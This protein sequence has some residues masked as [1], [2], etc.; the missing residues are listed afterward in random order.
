[1]PR[2]GRIFH[3]KRRD[4]ETAREIESYLE[5]EAERHAA[6][7]LS[8]EAARDAARRKLGN[9]TQIH[10]EIYRMNTLGFL[11]AFVKDVA[12]GW[13]VLLKA[14]G[15]TLIGVLSLALGIGA[16]TTMFSVVHAVLLRPLP[17]P[18]PEQVMRIERGSDQPAVTIPE[19]QF[20]KANAPVFASAAGYRG[21]SEMSLDAGNRQEPVTALT[22]TDDFFRTL[23]MPLALGREFTG[24]E[25]HPG[26]ARAM[27]LGNELWRRAFGAAPDAVGRVVMLDN[28]RYTVVGVAPRG[29][30]FPLAADAYVPVQIT[31]S[32][33]DR[34]M[35][36][37]MFARLKPGIG[38]SPPNAALSSALAATA[39]SFRESGLGP[40]DHP[41]MQAIPYQQSIVG[42][43]RL[44]LL[45]LFGVV[46]ALLLIAC[47]NLSGLLLARFAARQKEVAV[48]L[49]LGSGSARLVAQF[50]AENA[51][52]TAAGCGAG[53]LGAA[54]LL[55]GITA[56]VPFQL[57]AGGPIGVDT[58]TLVFALA[59]SLAT[60]LAFSFAP[61]VAARRMAVYDTLKSGG[62]STGGGTVRLGARSFL[63]VTEV[64]LS[65][66]LLVSAAL[67]IQSLYRM[68]HEPLGFSPQGVIA[69]TTPAE[70]YRNAE[71]QKAFER[72][73][74]D[75]LTN[76]PGVRAAGAASQL[77]L[78]GHSNLPTEP[79]GHPELNIGG[80][81]VRI[82]TPGYF[83]ALR[84]P[85]A[86]GRALAATDSATASPV[87]L[88]NETVARKWWAHE[89]PLGGQVIV[90]R[91]QGRD[92]MQDLEPARQVVG[93]VADTKTEFLTQPAYPTVY[94]AAAQAAR[95]EGGKSWVVRAGNTAGL[96]E[97]LR[98]TVAEIDPRQ[99]IR[100]MREMEDIVAANTTDS[101][102]DAWL[103]GVF[104]ALA[105]TLTAIGVYGLLAFSV[106]RRTNEFGI[107][108]ALGASR[109][110]VMRLVLRQGAALIT[111]GLVAGLAGSLALTKFLSSLLYSVKPRD[112]LS[113]AAVAVVL[114]LS[115]LAASTYRRYLPARYARRPAVGSDRWE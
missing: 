71:A 76:L 23:G 70:R 8:P 32:L 87:I 54:W 15:Y 52:L 10:E 92:F 93:I 34:G 64:A 44:K 75:R 6:R 62:R 12:Y 7:G 24:A 40:R 90:G 67:L 91:F 46:G 88:V 111:I 53:L 61:L 100:Q 65:V 57:P 41:G 17:Y 39:A 95:S 104:A 35:N 47:L 36:T 50:L 72:D 102:F 49:A 103:F 51:L 27:V 79:V 11:E 59:I 108:L 60:T 115:F 84:I 63:V 33:G 31:N 114:Q 21:T 13:R 42:D 78:T 66:T 109:P 112:P 77:P 16:N 83:A 99:R 94:I 105:L 1:M 101:R 38:G 14:P 37:V 89:N 58:E 2:F 43:V 25:T 22:V 28:S 97:Q 29:F 113:F 74:L 4:R 69:F 18:A 45:L 106:A 86:R 19:L 30:W 26:T 20:W 98:R 48:R 56:L 9:V 55:R 96:G 81:E 80:M 68:H 5:F 85:I 73:L 110:A 3:R 107:R 82:V